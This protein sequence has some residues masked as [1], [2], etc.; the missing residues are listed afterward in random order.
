MTRV[1]LRAAGCDVSAAA[2]VRLEHFV[3]GLLEEN[4]RVNLVSAASAKQ[5]WPV[6]ICDSL[7]LLPFVQE[8]SIRTLLDL[9]SGGGLPGV[10]LACVCP[11]IQ[12]TL[13][14]ATR[15]KLAAV[16]RI[17]A[18]VGLTNVRCA[19]GRAE[20][21][22]HDPAY[23]EQFDAVTAR[24]VAELPELVELAAGF[25]RPGGSAWFFKTQAAGA[26]EVAAAQGAASACALE[27]VE[28]LPYRVPHSRSE[29]VI[30]IGRAHV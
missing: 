15:K 21:L 8:R 22:A 30:E 3:A 28:S 17:V 5:V 24:A 23:R 1:Q 25:L 2:Y 19:W 6:H 29:R 18:A 20:M 27:H 26:T 16:E 13:L 7:A 9:G 14:D 4:R 12:V 11:T 10:P